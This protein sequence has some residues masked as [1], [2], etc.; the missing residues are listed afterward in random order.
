MLWIPGPL[1]VKEQVG[2]FLRLRLAILIIR[3]HVLKWMKLCLL[4][5]LN[6]YVTE[7]EILNNCKLI[8]GTEHTNC[9]TNPHVTIANETLNYGDIWGFEGDEDSSHLLCWEGEQWCN[10]LLKRLNY[11]F[12]INIEQKI[13]DYSNTSGHGRQK[14]ERSRKPHSLIEI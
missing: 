7:L 5:S 10:I 3:V 9:Y 8:G 4:W 1:N 13:V 12:V 2:N 14:W 6:I 11:S